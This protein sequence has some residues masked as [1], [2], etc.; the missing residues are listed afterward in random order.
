LFD[1]V[2]SGK[3]RFKV[4]ERFSLKDRDGAHKASETRATRGSIVLTHLAEY[5]RELS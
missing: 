2:A 5:A 1:V 4:N 3:V